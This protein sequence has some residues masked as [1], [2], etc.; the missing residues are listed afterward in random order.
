MCQPSL[1]SVYL[2]GA[3]KG[4]L[5]RLF[6]KNKADVLVSGGCNVDFILLFFLLKL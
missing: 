3:E 1:V 2:H 5:S 6:C 4:Q